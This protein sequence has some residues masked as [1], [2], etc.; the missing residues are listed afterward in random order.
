MRGATRRHVFWLSLFAIAMAQLEATVVVYLRELYYPEEFP[1]PLAN[2]RDR[3]ALIEI[4]R[5][6]ATLVMLIAVAKLYSRTDAWRQ[7]GAF[8]YVFGL[9]DVFY[10]VGQWAM[11]AWPTSLLDWD[12]LFLIPLPW[13]GPVLAPLTIAL[14]MIA[15]GLAILRLRDQDRSIVI[16]APEW[17]IVIAC[18]LG[19]I[20]LFCWDGQAVIDGEMPGPF[21]WWPFGALLATAS[22]VSVRVWSRARSQSLRD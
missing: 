7:Y 8:L 21:A 15:A 22:A 16:H 12:V 19:L 3:I 13:L 17:A 10:Y 18:A 5:E 11:L 2:I 14:V 1:F 9:W 4:I 6:A 20:V